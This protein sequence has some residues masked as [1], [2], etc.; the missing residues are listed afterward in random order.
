M[1]QFSSRVLPAA[2]PVK[3]YETHNNQSPTNPTLYPSSKHFQAPEAST[4]SPTLRPGQQ[5][6]LEGRIAVLKCT[7]QGKTTFKDADKVRSIAA[8]FALPASQ[9]SVLDAARIERIDE[10]TFKC[11]VGGISFFNIRV[12]PVLTVAVDVR[13]RGCDIRMIA[14][15]LEGSAIAVAQNKKFRASMSNIVRW[16]EYV[17]EADG[18]GE[19]GAGSVAAEEGVKEV[20]SETTIQIDLVVPPWFVLPASVVEKTGSGIMNSTLNIMVS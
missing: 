2:N 9:Y 7:K 11:Y 1:K 4:S 18:D 6:P 10:S 17:P 8:Y 13:E 16:R 15:E 19:D 5:V 12:E 20:C 14:C 3:D